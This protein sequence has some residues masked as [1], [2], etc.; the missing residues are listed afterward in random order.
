MKIRIAS[1]NLIAYDKTESVLSS[2][3]KDLFTAV[4]LAFCV[5]ISQG[6]TWWTFVSGLFFICFLFGKVA[7]IARDRQ[8]KFES[9]ADFKAWVDEQAAEEDKP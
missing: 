8:T 6:S 2:V 3:F 5:Y 7:Y 4:M 9:W 1:K